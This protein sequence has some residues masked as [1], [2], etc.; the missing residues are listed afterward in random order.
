M[1][2][3]EELTDPES[4]DVS[5]FEIKEALH[6][7]LW[8]SS[9]LL[10]KEICSTLYK[11]AKDFWKD[12]EIN[13]V[14]LIDIVL[15]GSIANYAWSEH[16]DIDVHIIVNY[17]QVDENQELVRNFFGTSTRRW[18]KY[19]CSMIK[20]FEVEISVC[21]IDNLAIHG[22]IYSVKNDQWVEMPNRENIQIDLNAVQKKAAIIMD[23]IDETLKLY[24]NK[25]YKLAF[26]EI[27]KLSKKL[28]R[29]RKAGLEAEGKGGI[30]CAENLA[31]K[32]IRRNGYLQKLWDAKEEIK[33]ISTNGD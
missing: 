27:D 19:Y 26:K 30:Y 22:G 11:I 16:S 8:D 23:E 29:V 25:E 33:R 32:T 7:E 13:W 24:T 14:E 21:D 5:S 28:R 6:P 4:I 15:A 3:I 9:L 1:K 10:D 17:K 2:A 31:F 20:D 18:N 12:L